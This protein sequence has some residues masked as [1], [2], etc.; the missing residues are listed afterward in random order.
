MA[1]IIRKREIDDPAVAACL[2]GRDTYLFQEPAWGRVLQALGYPVA[3]YCLE[4][5]GRVVLAQLAVRV[6][7][8]FFN[9]FYGGLPYGFAAGDVSR[10]PEFVDRLAEH[11]RHHRYHRIRLSQNHYDPDV[12]LP[13]CRVQENVLHVLHLA[14]RDEDAVWA[15]F[16]K[17]VRRDVRLAEKRGVV[18]EEARSPE[19]RDEIFA[20]YNQTMARNRTFATW[21]RPMIEAMWEHLVRPGS[22]E[23]LLARHEGRPLAAI[24]TFYSGPR[25]FYFLGASSGDQRNLCPND[26][27]VWEAIRR[28][29]ARG[30][31]DFDMM[32]SSRDDVN[33]IDFKAK[34]GAVPYPFRFYERD[35]APLM[36]RLANAAF[37][38]AR[39]GLGAGLLRLLKGG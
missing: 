38:F 36:C 11:A 5:D 17:R 8:G 16:K 7:L 6:K 9:L 25:C 28:A 39:T 18:V 33:L 3:Y 35:L 24:V 31:D 19:A 34:W 30:C 37:W 32:S 1:A 27:V 2:D 12:R 21:Q 4:D 20:M 23:M 22:G 26:A 13:A 15:D 10:H 29:V 14:G